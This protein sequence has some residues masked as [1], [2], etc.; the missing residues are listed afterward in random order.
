MSSVLS[1]YSVLVV[2]SNERFNRSISQLLPDNLYSPVVFTK[3]VASAKRTTD[4]E[5]FDLVIINSPLTDDKGI[6]FAAEI[7]SDKDCVALLLVSE[8]SYER[9]IGS[10]IDSG[11]MLL[12]KPTSKTAIKQS[13]DFMRA[14]HQRVKGL[15]KTAVTVEEKM[16]EIRLVNRAKWLLIENLRMTEPEAHRYIEKQSMDR[17]ISRKEMAENIL[18]S[19][20]SIKP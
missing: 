18:R 8:R 3:T 12:Q 5:H 4:T 17:C 6:S 14:C 16:E 20:Q 11:V 2:S 15:H 10:M 19:Y 13:L 7:T 1:I 9:I